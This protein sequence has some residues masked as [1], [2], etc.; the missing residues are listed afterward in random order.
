MGEYENVMAAF[1][2]L[3][4][5]LNGDQTGPVTQIQ[6][7]V[8]NSYAWLDTKLD[9]LADKVA[10]IAAPTPAPMDLDAVRLIVREELAA[11]N[12]RFKRT[13]T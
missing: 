2:R 3:E 7:G 9:D 10:K 11:L 12:L 8:Y 5:Y 1:A 4:A 6:A 13:T